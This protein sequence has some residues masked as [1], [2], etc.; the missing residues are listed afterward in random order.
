LLKDA[1]IVIKRAKSQGLGRHI[2]YSHEFR[3]LA[4]E[5]TRTLHDLG[6]AFRKNQLSLVYQPQVSLRD[7]HVTGV[8]ALLRWCDADGKF[9]PPDRFIPIAEKSGLILPIGQWVLT[10]AVEALMALKKAGHT[11]IRMAVNVSPPQLTTPAFLQHLDETLGNHPEAANGLEI[12]VTESISVLGFDE[13]FA[14]LTAIRSRGVTLAIDDFGT[15]YSSLSYLDKIP[16]DLLKIDRAF[17]SALD[18]RTT[19]PRIAEMVIPLGRQLNMKVLAEG[20][21]TENQAALLLDMGC[22]EA[23]GYLFAKP[24]PFDDLMLWLSQPH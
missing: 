1:S 2:N 17:V 23:Q 11:E 6:I 20:V 10:M 13:V 19:G 5:H 7:G 18:N 12:E 4:R 22:E 8:E 9:I 15:G 24:M 16:A 14:Q 3:S 21:E